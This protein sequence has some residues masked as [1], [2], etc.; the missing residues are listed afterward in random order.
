MRQMV[1]DKVSELPHRMA[2]SHPDS[3]SDGEKEEEDEYF[4]TYSHFSIHH[5]MLSDRVRTGAYQNFI[6][7]NAALFKDKVK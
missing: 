3:D 1:E 6:S 7:K 5:E 2:T 4:S